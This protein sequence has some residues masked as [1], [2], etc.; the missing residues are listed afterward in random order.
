[1]FPATASASSEMAVSSLSI[2]LNGQRVRTHDIVSLVVILLFIAVLL[3]ATAKNAPG[4]V[5]SV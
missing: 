2:L 1:M 5:D 4:V 3:V